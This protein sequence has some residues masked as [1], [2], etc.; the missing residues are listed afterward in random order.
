[1]VSVE[2]VVAAAG[3]EMLK[4]GFIYAIS[5]KLVIE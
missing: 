2:V 3:V 4:L 1:M 5:Y